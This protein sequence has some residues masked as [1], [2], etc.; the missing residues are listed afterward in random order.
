MFKLHYG[1]SPRYPACHI[2][3]S[4]GLNSMRAKAKK[5]YCIY[6]FLVKHKLKMTNLGKNALKYAII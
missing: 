4:K 1:T 6:I 3:D 5:I 2:A